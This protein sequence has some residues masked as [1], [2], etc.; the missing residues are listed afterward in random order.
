MNTKGTQ[1]KMSDIY[2]VTE[3]GCNSSHNDMYPPTTKAFVSKAKAYAYY[4]RIKSR[5]NS[6]DP[7]FPIK[8][9]VTKDANGESA[10]QDGDDVKRPEGVAIEFVRVITEE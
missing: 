4:N 9:H 10:I 7:D 5:L 3:F 6:P 8:V 2:V 1:A